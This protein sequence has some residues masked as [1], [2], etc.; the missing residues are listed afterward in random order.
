MFK[1]CLIITFLYGYQ[2]EFVVITQAVWGCYHGFK[3]ALQLGKVSEGYGTGVVYV[4]VHYFMDKI[5]IQCTQLLIL[6][7]FCLQL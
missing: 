5:I 7:K 3:P 4:P 6:K 1:N 2:T